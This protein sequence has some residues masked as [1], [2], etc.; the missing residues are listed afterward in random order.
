VELKPAGKWEWERII[1]RVRFRADHATRAVALTLAHYADPDGTRIRPGAER[2]ARTTEYSQRAVLRSLS[3]LRELGLIELTAGA[4]AKGLKGG[5]DE[6]RLTYPAEI[7]DLIPMLPAGR[8]LSTTTCHP[9]QVPRG[10]QPVTTCH[11]WRDHLP[12]MACG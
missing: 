3:I 6:Y 9:W 7:L 11:P 10:Y 1:R 8:E 4:S 5:A 12:P 2:L